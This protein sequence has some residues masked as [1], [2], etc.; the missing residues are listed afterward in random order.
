MMGSICKDVPGSCTV[1]DPKKSNIITDHVQD[2]KINDRVLL[3]FNLPTKVYY[4]VDPVYNK[5]EGIHYLTEFL[6]LLVPSGIPTHN[7]ILKVGSLII[8][9]R[10]LCS[11]Q[12]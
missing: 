4:S 11:P 10:N 12:L 1:M 3:R 9:L 8:L 2:N 7:L 6:N 5:A